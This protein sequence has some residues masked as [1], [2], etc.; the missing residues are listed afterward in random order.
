M[1]HTLKHQ[2]KSCERTWP[3][4]N[5]DLKAKYSHAFSGFIKSTDFT[6]LQ[7]NAQ[8]LLFPFPTID[9]ISLYSLFINNLTIILFR[10]GIIQILIGINR[11]SIVV[12]V[13]YSGRLL[14]S[15]VGSK[16]ENRFLITFCFLLV[17]ANGFWSFFVCLV[18]E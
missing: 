7:Y 4:T 13:Q 18:I 9:F 15:V 16:I 5:S 6:K 10:E 11:S 17:D 14:I 2:I 1:D 3:T 8:W 12:L